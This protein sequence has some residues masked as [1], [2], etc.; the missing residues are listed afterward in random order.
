MNTA[1]R[2]CKQ[3][4]EIPN[5]SQ[6][7]SQLRTGTG[8]EQFE[9]T[10]DAVAADDNDQVDD[11]DDNNN[12]NSKTK[13]VIKNVGWDSSVGIA[14]RYGL[15]GSGIEQRWGKNF[16]HPSSPALGPTQPPVQ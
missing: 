13:T 2:P 12:N 11:D 14:T 3:F 10:N 15:D 16:L 5:N 9:N 6:F 4:N 1:D 8:Q 7:R